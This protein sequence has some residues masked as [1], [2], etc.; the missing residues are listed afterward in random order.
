MA[1]CSILRFCNIQTD[2]REARPLT[3]TRKTYSRPP[4]YIEVRSLVATRSI[5]SIAVPD[6]LCVCGIVRT[7]R[8]KGLC[9]I[10]EPTCCVSFLCY[11]L[12]LS[13]RR[14]PRQIRE[15]APSHQLLRS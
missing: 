2:L 8:D 11:Y 14:A 3:R 15:H 6:L 13:P 4:A 7:T 1:R 12:C 10:P 9:R 5:I